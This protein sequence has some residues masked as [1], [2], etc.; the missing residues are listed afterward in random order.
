M[1]GSERQGSEVPPWANCQ[2][3][4]NGDTSSAL[5]IAGVSGSSLVGRW[6]KPQLLNAAVGGGS[7]NVTPLPGSG[8]KCSCSPGS[9]AVAAGL[10]AGQCI[11]K[12][13]GNN[14]ANDGALEVLEHF[15]AFRNRREEA[16][17]ST[18]QEGGSL[19]RSGLGRE[20]CQRRFSLLS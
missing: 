7:L 4:L 2:L 16:L 12:V 19:G 20:P 6:E 10:C 18:Q 5:P 17:V 13:N 14:V 1:Q 11:L 15:Q 8:L 3:S 9:E